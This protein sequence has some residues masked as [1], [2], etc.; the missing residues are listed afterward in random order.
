MQARDFDALTRELTAFESFQDLLVAR[1]GYRPSLNRET[2]GAKQLA[3][4]YDQAQAQRND[5]RRVNI[6]GNKQEDAM[7]LTETMSKTLLDIATGT[8]GKPRLKTAYNTK[9]VDALEDRGLITVR[10]YDGEIRLTFTGEKYLYANH[11][12]QDA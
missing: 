7:Q 3:N 2:P 6:Y 5:P 11:P 9:A 10:D 8:S 4:A 12:A 1:G